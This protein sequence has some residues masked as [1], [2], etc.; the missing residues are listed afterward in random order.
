[1]ELSG[2]GQLGVR[3]KL[4]TRG[5]WA[6]NRLPR[7][8]GTAFAGVQEVSGQLFETYYMIFECYYLKPGVG[9]TLSL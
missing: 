1:M 7:A 4:C 5:W 8:V 9:L 3:D 6:W 2:E